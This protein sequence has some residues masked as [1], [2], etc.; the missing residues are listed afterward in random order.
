MSV[1][2]SVK[3]SEVKPKGEVE[4]PKETPKKSVKSRKNG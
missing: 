4:Q 2:A 3:R 1:I